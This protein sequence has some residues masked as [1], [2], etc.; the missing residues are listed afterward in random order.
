LAQPYPL[1]GEN[2]AFLAHV[3]ASIGVAVWN[4]QIDSDEALI[5]AAD[6]AMY[7]VKEHGKNGCALASA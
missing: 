5:Q 3:S 2:G 7:Q 4:E 6:R 1:Q